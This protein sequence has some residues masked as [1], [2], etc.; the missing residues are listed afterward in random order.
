MQ[1]PVLYFLGYL[2]LLCR[3]HQPYSLRVFLIQLLTIHRA[4]FQVHRLPNFIATMQAQ[5]LR[6]SIKLHLVELALDF[7]VRWQSF[8]VLECLDFPDSQ[9]EFLAAKFGPIDWCIQGRFLTIIWC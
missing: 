1:G 9:A 6:H 2:E 8:I 3:P 4:P 5:R 7:V